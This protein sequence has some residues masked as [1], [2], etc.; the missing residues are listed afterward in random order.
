MQITKCRICEHLRFKSPARL[1]RDPWQSHAL[2]AERSHRPP[3]K[4]AEGTL[5]VGTILA[6]DAVIPHQRPFPWP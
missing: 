5:P 3:F 2:L 6:A 1:V 4:P